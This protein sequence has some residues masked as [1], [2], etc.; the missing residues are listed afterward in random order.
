MKKLSAWLLALSL[1]FSTTPARSLDV[2]DTF[3]VTPVEVFVIFASLLSAGLTFGTYHFCY[4]ALS[5]PQEKTVNQMQQ[6]AETLSLDSSYTARVCSHLSATTFVMN[7]F[8]Y[9]GVFLFHFLQEGRLVQ[10]NHLREYQAI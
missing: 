5:P 10:R 1:L 6:T 3:I 2:A 8:A 7:S 9:I 4:M